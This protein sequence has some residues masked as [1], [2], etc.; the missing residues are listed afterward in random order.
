MTIPCR[1]VFPGFGSK[2]ARTAP[3]SGPARDASQES[4]TMR[5][6]GCRREKNWKQDKRSWREEKLYADEHF[7]I[8]EH[9]GEA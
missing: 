3:A 9:G 8:L 6:G 4:R 2:Q 5:M 1:P 7:L